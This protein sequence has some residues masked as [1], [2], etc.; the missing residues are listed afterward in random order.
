MANKPEIRAFLD[1]NVWFSGLYSTQNAP[2]KILSYFL[3]GK[4]TIVISQQILDELF[5]TLHQKHPQ[6]LAAINQLL[7]NSKIEVVKD[8]P[9]SEIESLKAIL[10]FGDAIIL[11]AAVSSESDVFVTGDNHFLNNTSLYKY[12]GILIQSPAVFL[13][14]L[15]SG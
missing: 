2:Y 5:R 14:K 11:G 8:P 15:E 12:T 4:I 1:T 9:L 3:E 7:I 6:G 10:D 13:K